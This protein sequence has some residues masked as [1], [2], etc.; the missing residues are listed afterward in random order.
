V[1]GMLEQTDV[2]APRLLAA[3]TTATT[4]DLPTLLT[5][6][7]P[8]GPP[9]QA[10]DPNRILVA[11]AE[12]LGATPPN[13]YESLYFDREA[14]ELRGGVRKYIGRRTPDK[15]PS[16][17]M[18][19]LD[20]QEPLAFE[21]LIYVATEAVWRADMRRFRERFLSAPPARDFFGF[22]KAT[23]GLLH[24]GGPARLAVALQSLDRLLKE[25][26]KEAGSETEVVQQAPGKDGVAI[27]RTEGRVGNRE[28][29]VEGLNTRNS[30]GVM[31]TSVSVH[32]G[33]MNATATGCAGPRL[34]AATVSALDGTWSF[35]QRN[36]ATIPTT[37][38][39]V[40]R[41]EASCSGRSE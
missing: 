14:Q 12:M 39:A 35:R 22:L 33:V 24:I 26:R 11:L 5:T 4:C 37:V 2:P 20:Y 38:C 30:Q 17:Y 15:V 25:I 6:R 21:F 40:S 1:L 41:I 16:S 36:I 34:G 9:D 18:D 13:G 19:E 8:G 32:A 23:D 10:K 3:D 7:L 29:R 27:T 28:L 31:A